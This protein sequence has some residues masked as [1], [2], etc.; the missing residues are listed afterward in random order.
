MSKKIFCS[1]L[2]ALLLAF[3]VP[4]KAQQ[5][6]K[7]P[8]IGF[9]C[10]Q[11]ASRSADR[12]EAFRQGLR[13]LGYSVGKSILIEY[14]WADGIND[15][16][17]GFAAELVHLN[18]DVIVA[19]GGTPAIAAAKNATTTIPIVFTGGGDVV[20]SGLAASFARPGGN[21]TG[22]TIGGP[23]LWGKRLEILKETIPKLS[24]VAYMVN[25][26]SPGLQE[27]LKGVRA[28]AEALG[29]QL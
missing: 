25:P 4:A 8:R 19:S 29:V 2:C 21:L 7:V 17:P 28:T 18:V 12:A 3:S 5:V 6:K 15:R 10:A 22:V 1:A 11:S 27:Q 14:R 13:E 24:G 23:E 20:A 9:L 16:L 26:N